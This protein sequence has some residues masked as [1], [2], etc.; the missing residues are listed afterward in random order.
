LW[1]PVKHV[2]SH[3]HR[4]SSSA[5][6]VNYLQH[7]LWEPSGI[8]WIVHHACS[9]KNC[10]KTSHSSPYVPYI[11]GQTNFTTTFCGRWDSLYMK[12]LEKYYCLLWKR[13]IIKHS[14]QLFNFI[15]LL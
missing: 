3:H 7:V 9:K 4:L 1:R 5:K 2:E 6:N 12:V 11:I 8:L 15:Y 14:Q 10:F 13:Q